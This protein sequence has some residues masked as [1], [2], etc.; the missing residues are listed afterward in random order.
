VNEARQAETLARMRLGRLRALALRHLVSSRL[1]QAVSA[2][3]ISSLE[4][5]N[6]GLRRELARCGDPR[7]ALAALR[8]WA[9]RSS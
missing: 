1:I 6:A 8:R 2:H 5:D 7:R 3:V 4:A 9:G